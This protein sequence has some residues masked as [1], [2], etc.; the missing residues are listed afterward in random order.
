MV[1]VI[2]VL[3]EIFSSVSSGVF[4]YVQQ[5]VLFATHDFL[6]IISDH[7][8]LNSGIDNTL[9]LLRYLSLHVTRRKQLE[10]E[11]LPDIRRTVET[12]SRYR[13][14]RLSHLTSPSTLKVAVSFT[15]VQLWSL[16]LST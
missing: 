12:L 4:C 14:D 6:Y 2:D 1:V 9:L 3:E 5:M 8:L 15:S 7:C 10:L 11:L 16:K 13:D